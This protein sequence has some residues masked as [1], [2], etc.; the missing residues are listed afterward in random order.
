MVMLGMGHMATAQAACSVGLNPGTA[1][2]TYTF[3]TSTPI[4]GTV[5]ATPVTVTLASCPSNGK[6]SAQPGNLS[7]TGA[8]AASTGGNAI[9]YQLR[10]TTSGGAVWGNTANTNTIDAGNINDFTVWITDRANSGL[11]PPGTYTDSVLVTHTNSGGGNPITNSLPISITAPSHC[12][13]EPIS[14]LVL[15]Y[16]SFQSAAESSTSFKVYCNVAYSIAVAPGNGTLAGNGLNYSIEL[17]PMGGNQSANLAG[18]T[19]TLTGKVSA[20]QSGT[21]AAAACQGQSLHTVTVTY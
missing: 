20:G 10:Q 2:P 19:H 8:G 7:G 12:A 5:T 11:L 17:T 15:P 1:T 9:N 13:I 21:C 16:T 3:S 18:T 4:T 14:N 6:I